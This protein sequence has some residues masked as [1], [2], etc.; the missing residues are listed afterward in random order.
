MISTE[1]Y[2]GFASV[3]AQEQFRERALQS[4][5]N[6]T[7][8]LSAIQYP[9]SGAPSYDD[10][11]D[12]HAVGPVR[13]SDSP[14]M[15][16]RMMEGSSD[17]NNLFCE[18]GPFNTAKAYFRSML[19]KHRRP[20]HVMVEG[21][22]ELLRMFI[23]WIPAETTQSTD[24]VY[25][26]A[27]QD[28]NLQN[29]LVAE[30]GTLRGLIDWDGVAMVPRSVGCSY[31]KW[32]A[33]DWDPFHYNFEREI[34]CECEDRH[35]SPDEM[36]DYRALYAHFVQE[37]I[38]DGQSGSCETAFQLADTTRKS[39]LIGSIDLAAKNPLTTSDIVS[40]ILEKIV[41][42]TSQESFKANHDGYSGTIEGTLSL[43]AMDATSRN[44]QADHVDEGT[45]SSRT[46]SSDLSIPDL[47]DVSS[48]AKSSTIPSDLPSEPG[49]AKAKPSVQHV[50]ESSSSE[51]D[52]HPSDR[53]TGLNTRDECKDATKEKTQR[54]RVASIIQKASYRWHNNAERWQFTKSHNRGSTKT[55]SS[56][57]KT[58]SE[59]A[60]TLSTNFSSLSSDVGDQ[61]GKEEPLPGLTHRA[62]S[63][64]D[65]TDHNLTGVA[66]N[67]TL[68]ADTTAN[69][70][71]ATTQRY[72]SHYNW[73]Q[74]A[75]R[76]QDEEM[77][78]RPQ[79]TS[80]SSQQETESDSSVQ[81][82]G[83][84]D[85]ETSPYYLLSQGQPQ[86][87]RSLGR[88]LRAR[89][90]LHHD[91]TSHESGSSSSDESREYKD[92]KNI[93]G[94]LASRRK[95][96]IEWVKA[97][98]N[99][100]LNSD[101]GDKFAV[102]AVLKTTLPEIPEISSFDMPHPDDPDSRNDVSSRDDCA[103]GL[104]AYKH[105]KLATYDAGEPVDSD[106]LGDEGFLPAQICYDLM[107]GTLDEARMHRLKQGFAAL[108]DSL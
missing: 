19:E 54:R 35:H 73:H 32:L 64:L 58:Q 50:L 57:E 98:S 74:G 59:T 13:V 33:F 6:A 56:E 65:H 16:N 102:N 76:G 15:H 81:T 22:Y 24:D 29:I 11:G 20:T 44:E 61:L 96:V 97:V 91:H 79:S 31:P 100:S 2:D 40:T 92:K 38:S 52:K 69:R 5:A 93:F 23:D 104:A 42:I 37:A 45:F 7:A 60:H 89:F 88:R 18:I 84:R 63:D 51:F 43:G 30:D 62:K 66:A 34:D 78:N 53:A 67:S 86:Q 41:H 72:G 27:H 99:T 21:F 106:K 26:L 77:P 47:P 87:K 71:E 49:Q 68:E 14:A 82:E 90:A 9:Q 17:Q 94:R 36:K 85:G 3:E 70:L 103:P 80:L 108:L 39:I 48:L 25:I 55:S 105:L 1:W 10:N 28:L 46:Q 75:A 95:R 107:D 12:M 101:S 8:Q 83:E 4:L